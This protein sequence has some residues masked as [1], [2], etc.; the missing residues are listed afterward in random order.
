MPLGGGRRG[1]ELFG[2][3]GELGRRHGEDLADEVVDELVDDPKATAVGA[4]GDPVAEWTG[5]GDDV[6]DSLDFG[7]GLDH[8]D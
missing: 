5:A 2:L 1:R 4:F 6:L 7:K 3:G 8:P